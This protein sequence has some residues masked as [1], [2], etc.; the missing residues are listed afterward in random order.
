MEERREEGRKPVGVLRQCC[1]DDAIPTIDADFGAGHEAR[2]VTGEEDDGALTT[3]RRMRH[4]ERA[5]AATQ[6]THSKI[7]R[8]THL[9]KT[10]SKRKRLRDCHQREIDQDLRDPWE[11]SSPKFSEQGYVRKNKYQIKDDVTLS[12]VSCDKMVRVNFVN[13]Y[14]GLEIEYP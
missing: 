11:S 14:P 9:K 2:S 7:L 3:M 10:N 4:D 6:Q 1:L 5:R 12:S 13:M 8:I